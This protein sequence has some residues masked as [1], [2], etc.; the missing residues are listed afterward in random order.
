MSLS[1][2]TT[3]GNIAYDG[4]ILPRLPA[5]VLQIVVSCLYT[6]F[7]FF[8]VGLGAFAV[9]AQQNLDLELPPN[10]FM[11]RLLWKHKALTLGML[12][13][14]PA[15]FSLVHLF[16][17]SLHNFNL[18]NATNIV[19]AAVLSFGAKY[20]SEAMQQLVEECCHMDTLKAIYET[21]FM[22]CKR[23]ERLCTCADLPGLGGSLRQQP[24]A[25]QQ[26]TTSDY[27]KHNVFAAP[28]LQDEANYWPGCGSPGMWLFSQGKT[29]RTY[30]GRWSWH[31][32]GCLL[33]LVAVQSEQYNMECALDSR[34]SVKQTA[35]QPHASMTT[36]ML[37]GLF[38]HPARRLHCGHSSHPPGPQH[39]KLHGAGNVGACR[40][41]CH[42][43]GRTDG[44][45]S[46]VLV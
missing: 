13:F 12:A 34:T 33:A 7:V 22:C 10:D 40:R 28:A 35:M 27:V 37:S 31:A 20:L 42:S 24:W 23:A 30:T 41:V 3:L 11:Q 4:S 18:Y 1:N 14:I 9:S 43:N 2:I 39:S 5:S 38:S 29:V 19:F 6:M 15:T 45:A 32:C 16:T 17:N 25:T 26:T 8:I 36:H 46:L 21:L 44:Y